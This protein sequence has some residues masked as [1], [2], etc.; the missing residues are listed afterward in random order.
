MSGGSYNY[1]F[2]YVD[3]MAD[4]IQA[5]INVRDRDPR[6]SARDELRLAFARHLRLVAK[7]MHDI[8]WVDSVDL[9]LIDEAIA[10]AAV[11]APDPIATA[12]RIDLI[13][14]ARATLNL[15]EGT[16]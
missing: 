10:I 13:G 11:L 9:A 4:D 16:T 2:R 7:A 15:L 6:N 1:A 14:A 8:E 5:R 3:E 12:L